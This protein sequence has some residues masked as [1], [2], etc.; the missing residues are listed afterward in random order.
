MR[1]DRAD[2]V[3]L[4]AATGALIAL[5]CCAGLPLLATILGGLTLAA[6][7]GVAGGGLLLAAVLLSI[8]L[9]VRTP[10]RDCASTTRKASDDR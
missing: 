8:V 10:H 3:P 2:S 7:L 6:V 9:V 5:V 1:G 4:R